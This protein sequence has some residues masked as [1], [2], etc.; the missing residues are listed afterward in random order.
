MLTAEQIQERR[1]GIGSSEIAAILGEN[2]YANAHSVWLAK[3]GVKDDSESEPAWW[4]SQMEPIV[5]ARYERER[6]VHL[7]RHRMVRRGDIAL[8][9][10][11]FVLYE[12]D[13]VAKIVECKVAFRTGDQW[14][15]FDEEG[16]PPMY[17]L[18]GVWQ[19]GVLGVPRFDLAVFFAGLCKFS[20]YEFE[21]DPELF[22]Q[23]HKAAE[24]FWGKYVL[25]GT[26]PPVDSS[27]HAK[28]ALEHKH[29]WRGG[30]RP[31]S[32]QEVE[33]VRARIAASKEVDAAQ[34]ALDLKNNQLRATIGDLDGIFGPWGRVTWRPNKAGQRPLRVTIKKGIEL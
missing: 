12:E 26:P 20:I 9:S 10:P 21:H 15:G 5:G 13:T 7:R 32:E 16:V 31:A 23:M 24:H 34:E 28:R 19:C 22:S 11:D 30:M 25:T 8:A 33:L 3:M 29:S 1:S 6:D 17:Y 2:P 18:Q 14:D 27:E 4:G